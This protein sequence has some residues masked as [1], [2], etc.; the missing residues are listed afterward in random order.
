VKEDLIAI[1]FNINI[2]VGFKIDDKLSIIVER[3]G[4]AERKGVRRGWKLLNAGGFVIST[5][6]DL[7]GALGA[8]MLSEDTTQ[9][10]FTFDRSSS[11]AAAAPAKTLKSAPSSAFMQDLSREDK[12]CEGKKRLTQRLA[13]EA[14]KEI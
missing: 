7:A 8:L 1:P 10:K 5:E 13:S 4:Q 3:D 2:S 6:D 14:L 11:T 9:V 12:I